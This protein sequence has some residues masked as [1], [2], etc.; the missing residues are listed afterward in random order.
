[1]KRSFDII[2]DDLFSLFARSLLCWSTFSAR[3]QCS[4]TSRHAYRWQTR[5]SKRWTNFWKI[6]P[7]TRNLMVK[8][9]TTRCKYTWTKSGDWEICNSE[10]LYRRSV[11]ITKSDDKHEV[12]AVPSLHSGLY[13]V[14]EHSEIAHDNEPYLQY[15][16]LL[17]H[18]LY[19]LLAENTYTATV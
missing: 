7:T 19:Y 9:L 11:P 14:H 4:L 15:T 3:W 13:T 2:D 6:W 8:T 10:I 12:I 17:V 5:R 1:M 18:M 16:L